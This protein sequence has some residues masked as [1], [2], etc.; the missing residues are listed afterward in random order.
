MDLERVFESEVF[1]ETYELAL[2]GSFGVGGP[3]V[4]SNAPYQHGS[5]QRR[6]A[7]LGVIAG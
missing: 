1:W 6:N 5:R 2:A 7:L 3:G 4:E